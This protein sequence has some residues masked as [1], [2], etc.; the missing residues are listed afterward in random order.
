V[1]PFDVRDFEVFGDCSVWAK[2]KYYENNK[3]VC[4]QCNSIHSLQ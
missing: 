3:H 4:L 2:A 1:A